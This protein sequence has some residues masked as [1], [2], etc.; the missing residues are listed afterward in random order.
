M[1]IDC[2][3]AYSYSISDALGFFGRVT[4]MRCPFRLYMRST[5]SM[6]ASCVPPGRFNISTSLLTDFWDLATLDMHRQIASQYGLR[7][8][9]VLIGFKWIGDQIANLE[10]RGGQLCA[11]L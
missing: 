4:L 5:R 1:L 11:R 6:E 9:I 8:V 10:K 7:T 2:W 3:K